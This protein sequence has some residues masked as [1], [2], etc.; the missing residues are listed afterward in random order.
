MR[1]LITSCYVYHL[2]PGFR[3]QV[4]AWNANDDVLESE[5]QYIQW[6]FPNR[7]SS[8]FNPYA[9]PLQ[10]EELQLMR[11][12]QEIQS[13][14]I[15][16]YR[17]MLHFYGFSLID[18]QSGQLDLDADRY[19]QRF[20]HLSTSRHNWYRITRILKCLGDMGYERFKNKWLWLIMMQMIQH[21]RLTALAKPMIDYWLPTLRNRAYRQRY[22][23]IML[24][25]LGEYEWNP[26]IDK[27]VEDD[28][29]DHSVDNVDPGYFSNIPESIV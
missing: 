29:G 23:R 6:L 22:T 24:H 16:F 20:E 15:Q 25:H 19:E 1:R 12:D 17:M 4:Y 3:D 2:D 11:Q 13:W 8:Q 14:M 5:H 7:E 27:F 9:K 10:F 26:K 28:D 21:D 18:E